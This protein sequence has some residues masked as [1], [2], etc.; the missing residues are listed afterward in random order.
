MSGCRNDASSRPLASI[1]STS[2]ST[3]PI[4]SDSVIALTGPIEV[5]DIDSSR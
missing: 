2:R 5:A 4:L 3:S 1:A